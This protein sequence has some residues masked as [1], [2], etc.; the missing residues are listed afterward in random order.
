MHAVAM[1]ILIEVISTLEAPV[2]LVWDRVARV[3]G[4]N[5]ELRPF[6]RM[7]RPAFEDRM[8]AQEPGTL[9]PFRTWFLMFGFLPIAR[10]SM[11]L[12]VLEEGR[13]V[14]TSTSWLTRTQQ[15]ERTATPST[16][17][18]TVLADRL[19]I[20]SRG[21][22]TDAIMRA[23]VSATFRMRHRR[24]RRHFATVPHRA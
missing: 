1:P 8:T 16:D 10:R 21:M 2:D 6:A 20:E 12:E 9:P 4:A 7:T 15:H 17:G 13:F 22:V 19:T 18:S 11:Q 14:E 23:S 24:L 5:K 3:S